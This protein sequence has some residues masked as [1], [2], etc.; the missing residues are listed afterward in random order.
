MP[1]PAA[2][3]P[4]LPTAVPIPTLYPTYTPVAF[5]LTPQPTAPLPTAVPTQTPVDFG[6]PKVRLR[7]TIPALGLE[8]TL[9]GNLTNQLVLV[10]LA[11]GTSISL[12]NQ[13]RPLNELAQV[14]PTLELAPLPAGCGRCVWLSYELPLSGERGEGW[15]R[16]VVFL[17][18]VDHFF[19]TQLGPHFPPGTRL[20]LHRTAS[21]YTVA[22]TVAITA[23]GELWQ[24]QAIEGEIAPPTPA[25][26]ETVNQLL[27]GLPIARLEESYTTPC[28]DMPRETLLVENRRLALECPAL[29]LPIPLVGVYG[30][31]DGL[32]SAVLDPA[33]NEPLPS[34]RLPLEAVLYYQDEAG[35]QL[36]AYGDGQLLM[37]PPDG[38]LVRWEVAPT[39]IISLTNSLI[40]SGIIPR[41]VA[42]APAVPE[43]VEALLLVRGELGVY[44]FGWSDGIG[45]ALLPAVLVLDGWLGDRG[46]R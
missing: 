20:G 23:E 42:L 45:R 4:P 46:E 6:Q 24:W 33:Q 19:A 14:L 2:T 11:Q 36:V 31:L 1:P 43:E 27:A 28:P 35:N 34:Q 17:A 15:L 18:S 39:E 21:P 37:Q 13:P 16:D 29:S 32:A 9:E 22:H 26:Q 5:G 38:A 12:A 41:G 3:P 40:T 7:Y 30:W 10:D 25:D 8:R 44:E